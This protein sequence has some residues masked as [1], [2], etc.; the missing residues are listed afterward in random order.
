MNPLVLFAQAPDLPLERRVPFSI[1]HFLEFAIW[2]AWFVV[3]GNYLNSTLGFSRKDIGRI[4]ATMPLGTVLAPLFAGTLADRYFAAEHV[5]GVLHLLGGLLLYA[6]AMAR[7]PRPF[8][9]AA[10]VY[11][12]LY[13]PTLALVNSI[14]F[15]HVPDAERDFPTIR[16]F[17]TIGWIAAGLSLRF[18]LRPGEPVNNRPLLVAS[19]LSIAL[20]LFSFFLPH[21]PPPQESSFTRDVQELMSDPANSAIVNN[22][23]FLNALDLLREPSFAVFFGVSFFITLALAFYYSWTALYLENDAGVKPENVGPLMTIGQWMEIVFLLALPWFLKEFGMRWVLIIGMAAWGLRYAIFA[24]RAALPLLLVGVAL[25]G[26]CFD[27]FFAA[28]FIHVEQTAPPA[29]RSSAQS[30][31]AVLTYGLGMWLG[32]EASG[33][34]NQTF[35]TETIDPATGLKTRVTDWTKFWLVPCIGVIIALVAFVA[36]FQPA[37]HEGPQGKAPETASVR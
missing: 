14:P 36:L 32:T 22:I 34:L 26:I 2:G 4:Y 23:P 30:L 12:L 9:W 28:A 6:M 1:L 17:G 25:H 10:F 13:S 29:I 21:T 27:F 5:M 7:N 3:L 20:G 11:A 24:S 8:Y 37:P 31:F 15:A 19:G 16:V 18:L 35:T 33:W